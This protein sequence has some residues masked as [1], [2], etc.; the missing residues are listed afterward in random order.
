MNKLSTGVAIS[1][2]ACSCSVPKQVPES[3][4]VYSYIFESLSGQYE[5]GPS[6][7]AFWDQSGRPCFF[8]VEDARYSY[9]SALVD[10]GFGVTPWN[11]SMNIQQ[12]SAVG[13]LKY[14]VVNGCSLD[15]PH[16]FTGH[17]PAHSSALFTKKNY[18]LAEYV[19]LN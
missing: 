10:I 12:E 5:S 13:L 6:T 2:L 15:E 9:V 4:L 17:T 14:M 19:F 3:F 7:K 11:E 16:P 1:F 8:R 18:E